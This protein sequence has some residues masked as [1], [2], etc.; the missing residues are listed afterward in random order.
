MKYIK[1]IYNYMKCKEGGK[2]LMYN[3]KNGN[4]I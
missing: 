3:H 4:N 1:I 2:K